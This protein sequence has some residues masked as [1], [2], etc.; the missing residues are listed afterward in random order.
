MLESLENR[1]EACY[2]I[3]EIMESI[4]VEEADATSKLGYI[5]RAVTQ[6][7]PTIVAED[8]NNLRQHMLNPNMAKYFVRTNFAVHDDHIYP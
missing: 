5:R 6:A 1:S 4:L 3:R 8:A 7:N 2:M